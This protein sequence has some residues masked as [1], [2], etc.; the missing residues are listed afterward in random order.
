[1][2]KLL[3][4]RRSKTWLLLALALALVAGGI[5]L[6]V[7]FWAE[8]DASILR[9]AQTLQQQWDAIHQV[10]DNLRGALAPD[11]AGKA[12]CRSGLLATIGRAVPGMRALVIGSLHGRAG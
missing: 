6:A 7:L 3:S 1:M 11:T 5:L 12:A 8:R 9:I 10:T 2:H 4:P